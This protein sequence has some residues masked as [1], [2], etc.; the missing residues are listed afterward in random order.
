MRQREEQGR[1]GHQV[2]VHNRGVPPV[3]NWM[4]VPLGRLLRQCAPT[5]ELSYFIGGEVGTRYC[6]TSCY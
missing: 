6:A 1:E 2:T 3:G 5:S 4:S